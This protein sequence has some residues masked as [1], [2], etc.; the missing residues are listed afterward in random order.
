MHTRVIHGEGFAVTRM[1]ASNASAPSGAVAG[2]AG[3][4][5]ARGMPPET[6]GTGPA[7][8]LWA[9][10]GRDTKAGISLG[11]VTVTQ[12]LV[13]GLVAFG[14]L[15]PRAAAFGMAA[16]LVA[17][18]AAGLVIG[19]LA[20]TRPLSA[21]TS[22]ITALV[23]ASFLASA[24]PESVPE[25]MAVAMMLA[26]G[27]G[28]MLLV[29]AWAGLGRLAGLVPAPV[30]IGL[31]NAGVVLIMLGQAP[32]ALGLQPGEAIGV[33]TPHHGS[34][35]VAAVSAASMWLR[36]PGLPA[37]VAALVAGTATHMALATTA[38]PLGATLGYAPTPAVLAAGMA[39]AWRSLPALA[40]GTAFAAR[41]LPASLSLTVLVTLEALVGIAAMRDMTGRRADERRDLAAVGA[42]CLAAAMTGF[43]GSVLGHGSMSYWTSGGRGRLGLVV[44]AAVS[45]ACLA[46]AGK[47]IAVLPF[48]ALAGTLIG[49]NLQLFRWRPLF[50]K[51]GPGFARRAA[52]ALMIAVIIVGGVLFG[53][54]VSIFIGVLLS[55]IVFTGSMTQSI[56]RRSIRS[57]IGRSR[58]RR[59]A[60]DVALL[61]GAGHRMELVEVEGALFFGTA[62]RLLDHLE[63]ARRAGVEI[64][65]LDLERVTRIDATGAQRL[66]EACRAGGRVLVAPLHPASR[67]ATELAAIGLGDAVPTASAWP[68]VADALEAAEDGLLASLRTGKAAPG[69][70]GEEALATLGV[71]HAAIA[72]ILARMQP[73][74][75]SAGEAI[76]RAGHPSDAAYLLLSGETL[77][78]LPG[79]AGGPATRLAVLAAG[80]VFGELALLGAERRAADVTARGDVACLRLGVA[81]ARS[82]RE[83]NP[84]A[85]WHLLVAVARQ[86][87][88][89]LTAANAA[90]DG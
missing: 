10:I 84:D 45:V 15:G 50:P 53:L 30:T 76:L 11:L 68:T 70:A 12:A 1:D 47:A 90:L 35:L 42:G 77:V 29:A 56:I 38:I 63:R 3:P 72:P 57:P 22:A 89:N 40:D 59:P 25:A 44:R 48:A 33:G 32:L 87:A 37:S 69:R 52:D 81:E 78:S 83:E 34:L 8:S 73:C 16:A 43:P 19:L 2:K 7:P 49:L 71:P 46:G 36:V 80:T 17:S 18:A 6:A 67:A 26:A 62:D 23:T 24:G 51:R 55:I 13:H 86:T 74:H 31:V 85:A 82:L 28:V 21:G 41:L 65:I 20:S 4:G 9:G 88:V 79:R 61:A 14:S 27:A 75:F 60:E 58:V 64:I 54:A 66:A 5:R 39:E